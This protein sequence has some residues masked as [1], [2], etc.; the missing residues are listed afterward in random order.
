MKGTFEPVPTVSNTTLSR[1]R[2][3]AVKIGGLEY[4]SATVIEITGTAK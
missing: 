3:R 2:E 4:E 1:E